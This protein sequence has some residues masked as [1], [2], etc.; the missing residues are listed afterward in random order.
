MGQAEKCQLGLRCLNHL[1]F[2]L[3]VVNF[4]MLRR[5]KDVK[6]ERLAGSSARNYATVKPRIMVLFLGLLRREFLALIRPT[7]DVSSH[8]TLV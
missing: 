2:L 8:I 6:V 7:W 1:V 4:I 3:C 5:V